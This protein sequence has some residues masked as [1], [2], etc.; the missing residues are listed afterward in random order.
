MSPLDSVLTDWEVLG[1]REKRAVAIF[2]SRLRKGQEDYGKLT[3]GKKDWGKELMEELVDAAVYG[4]AELMDKEDL[5]KPY[6]PPPHE[7]GYPLP[8]Y[9]SK[10]WR[11]G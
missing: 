7:H 1:E 3:P 6:V 4:I 5:I 11:D 8:G 10:L 2:V 9:R